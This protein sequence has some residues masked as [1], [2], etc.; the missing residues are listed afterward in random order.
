MSSL[1]IE[2]NFRFA[3]FFVVSINPKKLTVH[4]VGHAA[5]IEEVIK[6]V[7]DKADFYVKSKNDPIT[8]R[9]HN[10]EDMNFTDRV[11]YFTRKSPDH[12]YQIDVFRQQTKPHKGW[13]GTSYRDEQ[14]LVRRFVYTEYV[15]QTPIAS[16]API[17]PI[18]SLAPLVP[19]APPLPPP[20]E[21][22]LA[23]ERAAKA[24]AMNLNTNNT[25]GGFP[26][27]V[28]SS[29]QENERF[30]QSRI[31]ADRN[32]LPPPFRTTVLAFD[33]DESESSE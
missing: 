29:L 30:K 21:D 12:D 16:L 24:R 6:I 5:T 9:G 13:T 11:L 22:R 31:E 1:L 27:S 4:I 26:S 18:A 25:I 10:T 14:T 2:T 20:N 28:I 3:M 15:S 17:A 32:R 23:M 33:A 8:H 7:A 19:L